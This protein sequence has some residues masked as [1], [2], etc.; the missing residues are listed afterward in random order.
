MDK[1]IYPRF[2]K[3]GQRNANGH[4]GTYVL[5]RVI[6]KPNTQAVIV[7]NYGGRDFSTF[8][9]DIIEREFEEVPIEEAVLLF[10]L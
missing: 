7:S 10:N 5:Y 3:R 1:K 2:F 4:D 6:Y 8:S 9:E